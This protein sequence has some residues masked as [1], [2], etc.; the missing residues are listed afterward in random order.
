MEKKVNIDI[1]SLEIL[2]ERNKLFVMPI[3]VILVS[4]ILVAGLLIPQIQAFFSA[5]EEAKKVS[6]NLEILKNNLTVLEKADKNSLDSKLST[7]NQI[8]PVSKDVVGILSALDTASRQSGVSLEEFSFQVG[9]LN[10]SPKEKGQ[11]IPIINLSISVVGD[12][13]SINNFMETMKKTAP[14]SEILLLKTGERIS[15]ISLSFFYKPL[16]SSLNKLNSQINSL[17]SEDLSLIRKLENFNNISLSS[18][19]PKQAQP[20]VNTNYERTV[21]PFAED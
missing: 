16:D 10:G 20:V 7:V 8:L 11:D 19:Q 9:D 13:Y 6:E 1:K 21:N 5:K 17:S 12:T 2:F 18:G 3:V 14:L 15:N 4:F